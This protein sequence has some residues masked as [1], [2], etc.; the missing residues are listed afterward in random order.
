MNVQSRYWQEFLDLKRDAR[1]IDLYQAR[2]ESIDRIIGGFTAVTS[3]V[4]IGGWAIWQNLSFLWGC[5]I[6]VSQVLGAVKNYLPYKKRL[7]ALAAL[8]PELNALSIAAE[9]GWFEV[10]RGILD[11]QEIYALQMKLKKK[12]Q[13]VV[14]KSFSEYSL[15]DCKKL[16]QLADADTLEYVRSYF[17]GAKDD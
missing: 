9:S 4:S 5:I 1:Y 13:D 8:S 3:S 15:P 6:A 17:S 7:R 16:M 11:E 2:T 10:S 14:H 12:K